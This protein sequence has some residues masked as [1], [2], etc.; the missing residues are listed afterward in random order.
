MLA[1]IVLSK[2]DSFF[3]IFADSFEKHMSTPLIVVDDGLSNATRKKWNSYKFIDSP[4]PFAF[5]NSVNAGMELVEDGDIIIWN[6]DII[7]HTPELDRILH[8]VAHS[9]PDI[10]LAAPMMNNVQN[11]D[12]WPENKIEDKFSKLTEHNISFTC[13]Y[14]TRKAITKVGLMDP[15]FAVGIAGAEDRDY[16]IRVRNAGLLSIIAQTTFA[17]HGGPEFGRAISNTRFAED[18]LLEEKKNHD[19][20]NS[21]YGITTSP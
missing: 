21:K 14:I 3:D 18:Q 9:R 4:K 8:K 6:D 2:I 7:I 15:G 16:C 12:Q 13:V 5:C 1:N 20:F 10:G 11:E 19:Y 17:Q